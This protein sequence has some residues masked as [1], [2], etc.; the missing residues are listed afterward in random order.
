MFIKTCEQ[1]CR[2]QKQR[3][4]SRDDFHL[5]VFWSSYE[6]G[7]EKKKKN[8]RL[9]LRKIIKI[10]DPSKPIPSTDEEEAEEEREEDWRTEVKQTVELTILNPT[11]TFSSHLFQH[12]TLKSPACQSP[13]S[14][15]LSVLRYVDLERANSRRS[16]RAHHLDPFLPSFPLPFSAP[17]HP[18]STSS[19]LRSIRIP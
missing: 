9:R 6:V 7:A 10:A 18:S 5:D 11:P 15:R 3:W 17:S 4:I 14:L 12:Q 16:C 1:I 8:D 19:P 13:S 2:Q